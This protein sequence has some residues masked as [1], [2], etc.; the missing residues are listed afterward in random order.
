[1]CFKLGLQRYRGIFL[2]SW[3]RF[4]YL[5]LD[6]FLSES[7]MWFNAA[8]DSR[9]EDV[10]LVEGDFIQYQARGTGDE[11]LGTAIGR[12]T[13]CYSPVK[14]GR[15]V[16]MT[17]MGAENPYYQWWCAPPH[18]GSEGALSGRHIYHLCRVDCLECS[19]KSGANEVIHLSVWRSL[20]WDEALAKLEKWQAG[21]SSVCLPE[22]LDP[23]GDRGNVEEALVAEKPR[24]RFRPLEGAGAAGTSKPSVRKSSLRLPPAKKPRRGLAEAADEEEEDEASVCSSD[25][26]AL[27]SELRSLLKPDKKGSSKLAQ[28]LEEIRSRVMGKP[29]V[30]EASGSGTKKKVEGAGELLLSRGRKALTSLDAR[31][32]P[33]RSSKASLILKALKDGAG[34]GND[35]ESSDDEPKDRS[36][37]LRAKRMAF[38]KIAK[39]SPGKLTMRG[40]EHMMEF[41][42]SHLGEEQ[43]EQLRPIVLRYLLSVYIPN[44]PVKAIGETAYRELRT[45]AE[46]M[47]HILKGNSLCALDMLMQRFKAITVAIKDHSWRSARWLELIPT[48]ADGAATTVDEDELIRQVESGELKIRELVS[49]LK[50]PG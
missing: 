29:D 34:A 10:L 43:G 33:R 22:D 39:D 28:R 12:I 36:D 8:L 4:D 6:G 41:I 23:S 19:A 45:L 49:K 31:R 15:F 2:N 48:D 24:V 5:S 26:A 17:H 40:L 50:G 42:E 11:V 3:V 16:D 44:H 14:T 32:E 9:V 25:S 37:H 46:S 21:D 18:R 27:D 7:V 1:M 20:S 47:D 38:K 35:V 13:T 30:E